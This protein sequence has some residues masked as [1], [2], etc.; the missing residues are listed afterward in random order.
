MLWHSWRLPPLND[1]ALPRDIAD[2]EGDGRQMARTEHDAD[3]PPEKATKCRNGK[4]SGHP[5]I[6]SEK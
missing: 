5:A 3:D 2:N 4:A 1:F 6:D